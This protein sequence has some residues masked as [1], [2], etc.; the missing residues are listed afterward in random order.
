MYKAHF[1]VSRL[2]NAQMKTQIKNALSKYDGI[3]M[4]NVDLGES[5][6]EVGYDETISE[7]T[8]KH[9]IEKVGCKV[10]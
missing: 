6:I 2:Q 7:E 8:I 10:E 4:V 1:N 3:S 5:S 9:C